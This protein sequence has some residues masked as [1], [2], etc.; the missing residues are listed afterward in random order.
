MRKKILFL[1]ANPKDT[2]PLRLDQEVRDIEQGLERSRK[3]EQFVL[4][5]KWAVRDYDLRRAML[6]HEPQIVHFS[7]HGAGEQG[8]ALEDDLGQVQFVKAE[9]LAEL[10]KLFMGK[11]EC[12]L[13]N[14]C[15]S[16]VQAEAI[17]QYVDYVIGMNQT[18][19]DKA[20]INFAVGF[21]D[22]LGS[23]KSIDV[24]YKLGCNA[25]RMAG[26]PEHL[27]PVLK[28]A[29]C[30]FYVERP[31]IEFRCHQALLQRGSLIRIKAPQ[32][33]G[34]TLLMARILAQMAKQGYRTVHLDLHLA[35]RT[36]FSNIDKFLQWLCISVTRELQLPNYLANYWD[37][38]RSTSKVNCTTY[39]EEYL[40]AQDGSPLV[41]CLDNVDQVFPY[42]EIATDFLGLLR[43][44][45]EK[46]TTRKIWQ[47]LRIIVVHS[48]EV[49]IPLEYSESPFNVG[50]PIEI[51]EFNPEQVQKLAEIYKLNWNSTQV[52][53]LMDM[54]GGHPYL[55]NEALSH[56]KSYPHL[57][58]EQILET[59][60]TEA[61]IYR[62]HLRRHLSVVQQYP[63]LKQALKEIVTATSP[64]LVESNLAY[65][66]DSMGVVHRS[67]NKVT[68][69][70]N[71]YRQYFCAAL[72][73][74]Q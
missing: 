19:G 41:L 1:A 67:G 8:L 45:H 27:T 43:A 54:V 51:P 56:L 34:K 36:D 4:V 66:L 2:S 16:E 22:G 26:I 53:Y 38:Q 12:V 65:K 74:T 20:A 63:E 13:L 14:A 28:Q 37:E 15:Y 31:L 61:G 35:E 39:F 25:I 55:V 70:C 73:S 64:V 57:S 68:P 33:M 9:A 40:L 42:L 18:I 32:E 62:N 71:L 23:G 17:C 11:V 6:D 72:E 48:T 50:L 5:Q 59:A 24:A 29:D 69:R 47:R 52:K 60:A 7:G 10:F 30:G 58:L 3:R 21:Y 46:A 49:Y 44:W